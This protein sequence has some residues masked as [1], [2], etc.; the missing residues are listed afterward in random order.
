MTTAP[1]SS[2]S[3]CELLAETRRV[4]DTERRT[5]AAL[6]S[7]LAEV[8]ARRLYLGEGYSSLFMYCTQALRLS[9]HAAYGRITAARAARRFPTILA[10]LH[11]GAISLTTVGLLAPHLTDENHE[12]VLAAARHKGK[13]DVERLVV[14]IQPQPDIPPSV[15]ALPARQAASAGAPGLVPAIEIE[16]PVPPVA[17][18]HVIATPSRAVIAPLAPKRYLVRMTVSEE[19]HCK[20]ER[21]RNLLRHQI[22]DGDPAAIFDRALTLLIDRAERVKIATTGRL[23]SAPDRPGGRAQRWTRSRQIPSSVRRAVWARDQG[24]CAFVGEGGRCTETGF[25]EFHHVVPFA[26]GGPSDVGNV[27]L[28]CRSHNAYEAERE[29]L[30]WRP[31]RS[32]RSGPSRRP[33]DRRV[34]RSGLSERELTL[35]QAECP[36][37]E[38]LDLDR[39]P[40][41]KAAP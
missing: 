17:T 33:A 25:L 27:Q 34:G 20:L 32:T 21:A 28:R 16:R 2:L 1:L 24:R 19:T 36:R 38:N 29:G 30:G 8:D 9:E 35:E 26:T 10:L 5:T 3:D 40:A 15:R 18:E 37:C 7:L 41:Q 4:A 6:V 23:A 22:P 11:D 14:A 31:S 12:A 39:L 13:R